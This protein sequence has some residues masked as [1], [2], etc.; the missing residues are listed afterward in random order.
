MPLTFSSLECLYHVLNFKGRP[1]T[2]PPLC[3]QLHVP[4]S[5][6]SNLRFLP[7]ILTCE[8][9]RTIVETALH[10]FQVVFKAQRPSCLH[11]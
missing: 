3:G 1:Q 5:M 9:G 10:T 7:V 2:I 4:A 8:T 11:T 6:E